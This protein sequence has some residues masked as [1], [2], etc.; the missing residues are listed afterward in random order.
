M[1]RQKRV[2]RA[3]RKRAQCFLRYTVFLA[4]FENSHCGRDL[5]FSKGRYFLSDHSLS[6]GLGFCTTLGHTQTAK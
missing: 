6:L 3:P 5:S 2:R 4:A 1:P